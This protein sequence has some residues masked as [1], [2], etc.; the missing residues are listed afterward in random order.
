MSTVQTIKEHV[1]SILKLDSTEGSEDDTQVTESMDLVGRRLWQMYPWPEKTQQ[2]VVTTLAPYSTGTATFTLDSAAVTGSGTT[3]SSFTGRKMARGY[4]LPI[5][6]VSA[7]ASSTGITLARTYKEATASAVT[8]VV[9]QDEIDVATDVDSIT[10]VQLL[11]SNQEGPM[12][13]VG[14]AVM[15]FAAAI[16][17]GTGKPRVVSLV[18]SLD[19]APT[20]RRIRVVPVPDA[21]YALL[22]TYEKSWSKL[23]D[24]GAVPSF[25]EN[26]DWLLVEG[27]IL[28]SQRLSSARAQTSEGQL[29]ALAARAWKD[30]QPHAPITFQR[31]PWGG[32]GQPSRAWLTGG[33]E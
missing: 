32:I 15:D 20:T 5:Y 17:T 18:L 19:T 22:V 7:N 30:A 6:R 3:W 33:D 21:V 26:R 10:S 31:E 12:L 2:V 13:A 8:Y 23:A 27:T 11:A 9:Y 14:R 29:A 16:Q 24:P 4:N 25:H 28:Y 1:M